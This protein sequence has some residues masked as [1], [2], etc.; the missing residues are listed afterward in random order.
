VILYRCILSLT[1]LLLIGTWQCG[2]RTLE[3]SGARWRSTYRERAGQ[4]TEHDLVL[5]LPRALARHGFLIENTE[6]RYKDYH[7]ETQWRYRKP[8]PDE[9]ERGAVEARTRIRLRAVWTGLA[10]DLNFEAEN[11]ILTPGGE[12]VTEAATDMFED[13]ARDVVNTIRQEVTGGIRV[14]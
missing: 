6:V 4:V 8:F 10:Y 13:F 11:A 5:R 9:A 3:T 2:P 12:W 7:I 14:F 1:A